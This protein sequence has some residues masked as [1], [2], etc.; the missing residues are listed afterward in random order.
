MSIGGDEEAEIRAGEQEAR[1]F[2]AVSL[3]SGVKEVKA[4]QRSTIKLKMPQYIGSVRAQLVGVSGG[5]F[6]KKDTVITVKKPLM[7][8]PTVPRAT[9][10]NDKFKIP[11]SVFA[12]DSD[13]QNVKVSLQVSPELKITGENNFSLS[14]S[15]VHFPHK[16]IRTLCNRKDYCFLRQFT[17]PDS[18][19]FY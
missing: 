3:F 11:V 6:V 4:G 8:L 15:F 9:K 2:K 18:I 12:M 1:R 19:G 16:K 13:V 10:P 5:A 17:I 7:V 14:F